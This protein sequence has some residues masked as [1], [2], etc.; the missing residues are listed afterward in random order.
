M[1]TDFDLDQTIQDD[2]KELGIE[3][4]VVDHPN[5]E[6]PH[7]VY[8]ILGHPAWS[9]RFCDGFWLAKRIVC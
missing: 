2:C 6:Y 7:E 9:S 4:A 3:L 1:K 5:K 8:C